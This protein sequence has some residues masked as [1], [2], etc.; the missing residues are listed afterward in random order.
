[1]KKGEATRLPHIQY[2]APA[3]DVQD[4]LFRAQGRIIAGP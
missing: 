2:L 3:F 4:C 1:M